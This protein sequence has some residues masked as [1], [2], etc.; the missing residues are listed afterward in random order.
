MSEKRRPPRERAAGRSSDDPARE[1]K[2][3]E[4]AVDGATT[5]GTSLRDWIVVLALLTSF[6][7]IPWGLILLPAS[8]IVSGPIGLSFSDAYLVVPLIPAVGLGAIAVW[9]AVAARRSG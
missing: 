1:T 4:N 3:V 2:G 7:L 9:S 5:E 8:G 6:L